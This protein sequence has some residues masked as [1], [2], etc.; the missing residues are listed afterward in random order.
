MNTGGPDKH[1]VA[2]TP[3]ND[4][5]ILGLPTL[6][7]AQMTKEQWDKFSNIKKEQL[8]LIDP[9]DPALKGYGLMAKID[10]IIK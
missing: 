10:K 5:E 2:M 3:A 6:F 9:W 4:E 1:A 7:Y 8:G